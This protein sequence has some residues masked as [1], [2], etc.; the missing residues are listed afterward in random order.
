MSLTA[1]WYV[2]RA[3]GPVGGPVLPLHSPL[4]GAGGAAPGGV[5]G[6]AGLWHR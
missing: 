6:G 4:V 3:G 1:S 2:D 5:A